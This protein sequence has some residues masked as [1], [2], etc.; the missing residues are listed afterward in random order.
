L[1]GQNFFES[2]I[3]SDTHYS[4]F[5]VI[6]DKDL[7]GDTN[8]SIF[9]FNKAGFSGFAMSDGGLGHR[10]KTIRVAERNK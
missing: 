10:S 3:L 1:F 9:K 2:I 4:C 5:V 8:G 6:V 7:D